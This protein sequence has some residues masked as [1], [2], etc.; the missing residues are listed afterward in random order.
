MHTPHITDL[1]RENVVVTRIIVTVLSIA[2]ILISQSTLKQLF[3]IDTKLK[4]ASSDHSRLIYIGSTET[5]WS[6]AQ[7]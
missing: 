3:V 1:Y 4:F 7:F 5:S 6:S 2:T